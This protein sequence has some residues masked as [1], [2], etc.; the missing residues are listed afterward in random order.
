M[1]TSS[2]ATNAT[3]VFFFVLCM[4]LANKLISPA[5]T[6]SRYVPFSF[7]PTVSWTF[8]AV[9]CNTVS[10]SNGDKVSPCFRPF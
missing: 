1:A 10:K 5:E 9:C 2:V 6:I 4:A 8:L 3:S 7:S